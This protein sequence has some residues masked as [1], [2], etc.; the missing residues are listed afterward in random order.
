MYIFTCISFILLSFLCIPLYAFF[1]FTFSLFV[2][3][4]IYIRF[5]LFVYNIIFYARW[6]PFFL[7][8]AGKFPVAKKKENRYNLNIQNKHE[9]MKKI[10]I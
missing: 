10:H 4:F 3:T 5:S 1:C 6:Q 2:Y 9:Y 8:S 7:S